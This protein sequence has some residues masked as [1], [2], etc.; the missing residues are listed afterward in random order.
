[1]LKVHANAKSV[2]AKALYRAQ[3]A[4]G[5]ENQQMA[6][7]LGVNRTTLAR[8]YQTENIDPEQNAGRLAAIVLRVYRSVHTLMGGDTKNI[9]HWLNTPNHAFADQIPLQVMKS[10][11][12]LVSVAQYCDAMRGRA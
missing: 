4:M 9:Q 11:D 2:L 7:I 3:V 12:G 8:V 1:M 10:V 5:V 6:D